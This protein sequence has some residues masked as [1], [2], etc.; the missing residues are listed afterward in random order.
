MDKDFVVLDSTL[1]VRELVKVPE[2]FSPT[3]ECR[4]RG[5]A[6]TLRPATL[7]EVG[8]YQLIREVPNDK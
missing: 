3:G 5:I 8:E 1:M 2:T 7:E 6:A 4:G